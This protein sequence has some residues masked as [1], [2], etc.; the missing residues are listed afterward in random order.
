MFDAEVTFAST[1]H[2][3][4]KPIHDGSLTKSI[5]PAA[6][7]EMIRRSNVRSSSAMPALTVSQVEQFKVLAQALRKE[8]EQKEVDSSRIV[9]ELFS[10]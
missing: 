6:A 7:N 9:A 1:D 5:T 2:E 8:S 10:D 4:P 3:L